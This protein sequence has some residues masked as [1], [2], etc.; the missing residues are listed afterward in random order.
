MARIIIAYLTCAV[1][2]LVVCVQSELGLSIPEANGGR[3]LAEAVSLHLGTE[4][5]AELGSG[6][7]W[8][9]RS[10]SPTEIAADP[11]AA[12]LAAYFVETTSEQ[13]GLQ[14]SDVSVSSFETDGKR[15]LLD[16]GSE[17]QE[18]HIWYTVLSKD[19]D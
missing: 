19:S 5:V 14:P 15:T 1:R 9:D 10:L 6:M 18:V 8:D 4:Y 13:L 2:V 7:A 3:R 11:E 12:A 16:D 17:T